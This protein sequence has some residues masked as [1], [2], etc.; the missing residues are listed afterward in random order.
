MM[1]LYQME[2]CQTATVV[3]ET[4]CEQDLTQTRA[5]SELEFPSLTQI[6]TSS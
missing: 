6:E 2:V 5:N 1:V 3:F 4:M